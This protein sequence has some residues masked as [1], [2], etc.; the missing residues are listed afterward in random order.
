MICM[1]FWEIASWP[2]ARLRARQP[3]DCLLAMTAWTRAGRQLLSLKSVMLLAMTNYRP[4]TI[5]G[6]T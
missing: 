2:E 1:R 5:Q 3:L 4:G 6:N